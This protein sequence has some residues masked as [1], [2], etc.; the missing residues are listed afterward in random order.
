MCGIFGCL[1]N[2]NIELTQVLLN[3]LQKLQYRGYDSFGLM[4]NNEFLYRALGSIPNNI[5]TEIYGILGIAHTRWAT[6]GE[7]SIINT[8]PINNNNWY[9]VHNGIIQNHDSIKSLYNFRH[10]SETD[11]E[12]IVS[13]ANY[14]YILDSS[15]SFISIVKEIT[16]LIDGSYAFILTSKYFPNEII[17]TCKGSPLVFS[18]TPSGFYIAS[19]HIALSDVSK[20]YMYLK[21]NDILNINSDLTYFIDSLHQDYKL[22]STL[23]SENNSKGS[24]EH[25]MIKEI[26]EQPNAI[27]NLYLGRVYPNKVKLGGIE[28]YKQILLDS[29]T[30]TLI[31]CGSSY[32]ACICS[33]SF[34]EDHFKH[35]KCINIELASDFILRNPTILK[36]QVY[37]ILSQSGETRDC[38]LACEL[39]NKYNGICI[40]INNRPGSMLDNNTIAGIHLN[41]GVE[42]SVAAT[43]SFTSSI[44]AL[45]MIAQCIYPIDNVYD[46]LIR[47]PSI[48]ERQIQRCLHDISFKNFVNKFNDSSVQW[49]ALGD[50]WG[51]GM[52][53]EASLKLQEIA[54]IPIL[55]FTGYEVKHGPLALVD[56]NTNAFCF[57]ISRMHNTISCLLKSRKATVWSLPFE[58]ES[59]FIEMLCQAVSYQLLAYEVG[60]MKKL[61]IDQPRNLAK[62][63]T[64]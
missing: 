61:P 35:T 10:N 48:L 60:K 63:V 28:Q 59:P 44:I 64:V 38:I 20:N 41:I 40:G 37:I 51:Y 5:D 4:I 24:Y 36:S 43:K 16:N 29:T 54:Y 53:R 12:I 42:C 14:F 9:V 15:R 23:K 17:A 1:L 13:L 34:L 22:Y 57:G 7:P 30:W 6:H 18:S 56:E 27:K 45:K 55:T 21:D 31:A 49:M 39:I 33:R 2:N 8:H 25:Y 58:K 52:A 19:D 26:I 46:E 32:N 50:G 3:G 47:I 11:T 62:S